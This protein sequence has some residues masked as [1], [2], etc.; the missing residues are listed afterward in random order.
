[1]LTFFVHATAILALRF[2]DYG[3]IRDHESQ[4]FPTAYAEIIYSPPMT[5][6]YLS[7]TLKSSHQVS[8]GKKQCN[9]GILVP[10]SSTT[11]RDVLIWP[12]NVSIHAKKVSIQSQ[13]T[14][15]GNICGQY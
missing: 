6:P 9:E 11:M 2:S 15:C 8:A 14:L 12:H 1:M 4:F 13:A 3:H 10:A 5:M 7:L